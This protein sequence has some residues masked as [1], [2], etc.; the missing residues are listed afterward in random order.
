[1]SRYEGLTWTNRFRQVAECI[2]ITS[3]FTTL[4]YYPS[5]R[6]LFRDRLLRYARTIRHEP[7]ARLV[8]EWVAVVGLPDRFDFVPVAEYTADLAR[9]QIDEAVLSDAVSVYAPA[10]ASPVHEGRMPGSYAPAE[11]RT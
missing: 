6:E 10:A 4:R 11:P 7:D 2:A 9:G 8:F 5:Q 3:V 1:V